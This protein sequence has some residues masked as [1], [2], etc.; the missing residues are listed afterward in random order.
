VNAVRSGRDGDVRAGV[1]EYAGAC[2]FSGLNGLRHEM[3]KRA[4]VEVFLS[5]LDIFDAVVYRAANV[6]HDV[7]S[8]AGDVIT[9]HL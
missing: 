1:D 6:F 7:F 8:A 9:P 5:N 3:E 4:R 2:G